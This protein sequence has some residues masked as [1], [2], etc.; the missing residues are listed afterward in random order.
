MITVEAKGLDTLMAKLKMLPNVFRQ[1]L[2][3]ALM[4]QADML[5]SHIKADKLSGQ[6]LKVGTTSHPH[7]RD[8]IF[9]QNVQND[10]SGVVYKVASG[11]NIPYAAIHEYGGVIQHPGSDKFQ[12]WDGPGGPV[13]THGTKPHSITIPERSY[14]RSALADNKAS[15]I[16][17]IQGS[18]K[19]AWGT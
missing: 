16:A 18:L 15:I 3:A 7:L 6:V 4:V 19:G 14:M 1:R 5:V 13:F 10:S 2:N 8:S 9:Q 17:A 12:A 11:G